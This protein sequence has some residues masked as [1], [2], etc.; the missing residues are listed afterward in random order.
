MTYVKNLSD[1]VLLWATAEARTA[2]HQAPLGEVT[3]VNKQG[4]PT[5]ERFITNHTDGWADRANDWAAL[6]DECERR[7]L[8]QPGCNCPDKNKEGLCVKN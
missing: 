3:D 1:D 8:K 6:S 4:K 2:A 5:G 7:G